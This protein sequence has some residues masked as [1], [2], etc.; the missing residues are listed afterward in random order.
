LIILEFLFIGRAAMQRPRAYSYVRLSSPKQ[1]RGVG[2]A[3]QLELSRKY[4]DEHDLDLA[5]ES[6]QDLGISAY[7]GANILE[8]KLGAFL[9]AV[10]AGT[11]QRG[12]FLLVESLD[13][14]SRQKVH[15]GLQ[16]FLQIID[17][18]ITIVSLSDG[19]VFVPDRLELTELIVSLVI[20]SRAWEESERKSVRLRDVLERKRR[21]ARERLEHMGGPI[22]GW[23]RPSRDRKR[24][25]VIEERAEL[26]RSIFRDCANG[27]GPHRIEARLNARRA[28]TFRTRA[29]V[30][31][32]SF[33]RSLLSGR[34][35]LGEFQ[36]HRDMKDEDGKTVRVPEGDVIKGYYPAIVT[37][38]LWHAAQQGLRQRRG[39]GGPSIAGCVPNL[40][41]GGLAKCSYCM[42]R[43]SFVNKGKGSAYFVCESS[44]RGLGCVGRPWWGYRDFETSFLSFVT[45]F[46]WQAA[47]QGDDGRGAALDVAIQA[48]RGR[49]AQLRERRETYHELMTRTKD[50]EFVARGLNE[51]QVELTRLEAE[52]DEKGLERRALE[53]DRR[54]LDD[55]RALIERLQTVRGEETFALRSAIKSRL[56][57]LVDVVL[58]APHGDVPTMLRAAALAREHGD[59]AVA[60]H[61][62][63]TS[64]PRR[65]FIVVFRDGR[66]RAVYPSD[67]DPTRFT[68]QLTS[69]KDEGLIRH[70]PLY[71][72]PVF[73]PEP[74]V[75]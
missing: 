73:P 31:N 51:I 23:L 68:M 70:T 57:S 37:E 62:E 14:I 16:L 49:I 19:Y 7:H 45:E 26:V 67:D 6:F 20:L 21:A 42:S 30:W 48:T 38:E 72:K 61:I 17:A 35:V 28:P 33:I 56:R 71:S 55:T 24:L 5:D 46:D 12:S 74:D 41:T 29:R 32:R 50:V 60:Q 75:A 66:M 8:G 4:A 13:R 34:A 2:L 58:V 43:M 18:G 11:I 1:L 39:T 54:A 40:F 9:D 69:S 52:L 64:D 36:P 22:L 10:R 3:R 59:A 53:P 25:E 65:R 47:F 63:K 15:K 44:R 27:I